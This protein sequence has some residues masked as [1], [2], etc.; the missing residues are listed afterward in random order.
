MVNEPEPTVLATEEPETVPSSAE[1]NTATFAGPPRRL[2]ARALPKSMKNWPTPVFSRNAPKSMNRKMN[3]LDAPMGV[4]NTPSRPKNRC[5]M[6]T[7]RLKPR[8]ARKPGMDWP[9]MPTSKKAIA[10][11]TMGRP[12]TRRQASIKSRM[13]AAPTTY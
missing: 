10:T 11:Q 8:L 7:C 9:K 13:P 4:P 12:L 5:L 1:V 2:P 6:I 3:V